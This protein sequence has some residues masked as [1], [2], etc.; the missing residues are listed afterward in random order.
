M[1]KV[2]APEAKASSDFKAAVPPTL[3]APAPP[4]S[5]TVPAIR[6]ESPGVDLSMKDEDGANE[7][8]KQGGVTMVDSPKQASIDVDNESLDRGGSLAPFVHE[9]NSLEL[10][11]GDLAGSPRSR[12]VVGGGGAAADRLVE[13]KESPLPQRVQT[14]VL[15]SRKP[16]LPETSTTNKEQDLG[17]KRSTAIS[18]TSS[19]L[20]P[21]SKEVEDDV[22]ENTVASQTQRASMANKL[23]STMSLDSVDYGED[24][25]EDFASFLEDQA[26]PTVVQPLET[27]SPKMSPESSRASTPVSSILSESPSARNSR[28]PSPAAPN[29]LD[30]TTK[31]RPGSPSSPLS[32]GVDNFIS[33]IG[34][35]K[36][37]MSADDELKQTYDLALGMLFR[38][39]RAR[40]RKTQ[41]EEAQRKF[42]EEEKLKEEDAKLKERKEQRLEKEMSRSG[43]PAQ[44]SPT[45]RAGTPNPKEILRRKSSISRDFAKISKKRGARNTK[46]PSNDEQFY[47]S[48]DCHTMRKFLRKRNAKIEKVKLE[49]SK[50]AFGAT[51]E[52]EDFEDGLAGEKSEQ[53]KLEEEEEDKIVSEEYEYANLNR[54][55]RS[56]PKGPVQDIAESLYEDDEDA[57]AW[58]ASK[59]TPYISAEKLAGMSEDDLQRMTANIGVSISMLDE[60]E[61]TV[62]VLNTLGEARRKRANISSLRL[63]SND[64]F[65]LVGGAEA[66]IIYKA[67]GVYDPAPSNLFGDGGAGKGDGGNNSDSEDSQNLEDDEDR[68]QR[69]VQGDAQDGMELDGDATKDAPM[70]HGVVFDKLRYSSAANASHDIALDLDDG[71]E[72]EKKESS[73][74]STREAGIEKRLLEFAHDEAHQGAMID[75]DEDNRSIATFDSD[76]SAPYFSAGHRRDLED[77]VQKVLD[78]ANSMTAGGKSMSEAEIEAVLEQKRT[79]D[80]KLSEMKHYRVATPA[81]GL[82]RSNS[83]VDMYS[84]Y[85]LNLEDAKLSLKDEKLAEKDDE[86]GGGDSM[87]KLSIST[88]ISRGASGL[89]AS[90][91]RKKKKKKAPTRGRGTSL[92][93]RGSSTLTAVSQPPSVLDGQMQEMRS[94]DGLSQDTSVLDLSSSGVTKHDIAV[95]VIAT[96]PTHSI[97]SKSIEDDADSWM[98]AV[99]GVDDEHDDDDD[100]FVNES[101]EEI[102]S[103][104]LESLSR[105]SG[106]PGVFEDPSDGS[107]DRRKTLKGKGA[108]HVGTS[109]LKH[110]YAGQATFDPTP[111]AEMKTREQQKMKISGAS[112]HI[113]EVQ[114]W[115]KEE[116]ALIPTRRSGSSTTG[117]S[118]VNNAVA[119]RMGTAS[120]WN[121]ISS[122]PNS[123]TSYG[124]GSGSGSRPSTGQFA[125]IK[126]T[127][128]ANVKVRSGEER[129]GVKDE[130]LRSSANTVLTSRTPPHLRFARR[131]SFA[132]PMASST[133]T[134]SMTTRSWTGVRVN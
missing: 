28:P 87:K 4:A 134:R 130:A 42:E 89:S 36:V 75:G 112:H 122:R 113:G 123:S 34:P 5:K 37:A 103:G 81:D 21:V 127:E 51:S 86:V 82:R 58:R 38:R 10:H 72:E 74:A 70:T 47:Q 18:S 52:F 71:Q 61:T 57:D 27:I 88:K 41:N 116:N 46:G 53:D 24:E 33:E 114:D 115:P 105:M 32:P 125:N 96:S 56:K 104:I 39:E 120:T 35:S 85:P 109:R 97:V 7:Q 14:P 99:A 55:I 48:V 62:K 91:K 119:A 45:E 79:F 44:G 60:K 29:M 128:S 77:P 65:V 17:A 43:S 101:V 69:R 2:N 26:P 92:F 110:K 117:G 12:G 76:S 16:L 67:G 59:T 11:P 126:L 73:R 78:A 50:S 31:K 129:R 30:F 132:H 64:Q 108:L 131:R 98:M 20:D 93:V 90:K 84:H 63:K 25:D 1:K 23:A 111:F 80:S 3:S 54:V 106:N 8:E 6:T 100:D 40:H 13:V 118:S 107:L 133:S 102:V 15:E 49:E 68:V 94:L 83:L 124:Y 19:A 121:T 9:E 22:P 95:A 66:E